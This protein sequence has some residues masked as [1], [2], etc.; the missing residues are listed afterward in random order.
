M[1]KKYSIV[2]NFGLGMVLHV[3]IGLYGR[4]NVLE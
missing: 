1:G 2:N 3:L 4:D